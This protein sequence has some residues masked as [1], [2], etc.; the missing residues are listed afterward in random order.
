MVTSCI[1]NVKLIRNLQ[2]EYEIT[3]IS[4]ATDILFMKSSKTPTVFYLDNV[5]G[6]EVDMAE[7]K[8]PFTRSAHLSPEERQDNVS[9]SRRV[10]AHY[11]TRRS[12]GF[13]TAAIVLEAWT[14]SWTSFIHQ[15]L[16]FL[17]T[18]L[19]DLRELPLE[20]SHAEMI[21]P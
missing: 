9:S 10:L 2:W 6:C 4:K 14:L 19:I 1:L 11:H 8:E 7:T 12:Q 13:T 18:R 3:A 16:N 20:K 5:I 17:C 15:A 21:P